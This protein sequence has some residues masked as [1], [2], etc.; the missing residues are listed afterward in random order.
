[1]GLIAFGISYI[2]NEKKALANINFDYEQSF[3]TI[4]V[5]EGRIFV[6]LINSLTIIFG[7]FICNNPSWNL[8]M[9]TAILWYLH[10]T[11]VCVGYHR[12]FSHRSFEA[13]WILRVALAVWGCMSG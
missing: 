3:F 2:I 4:Q 9:W 6:T 7:M 8:L 10:M 5:K 13:T 12:L 11:G 1:M